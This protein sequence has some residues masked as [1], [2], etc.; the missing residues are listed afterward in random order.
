MLETLDNSFIC[1]LGILQ[2]R[3]VTK[4]MHLDYLVKDRCIY[5]TGNVYRCLIILKS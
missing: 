1:N 3:I 5:L 4:S 2:L